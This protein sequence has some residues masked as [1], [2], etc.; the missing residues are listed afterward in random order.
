MILSSGRPKAIDVILKSLL[1]F[2]QFGPMKL[3]LK[4]NLHLK[5]QKQKHLM[6]VI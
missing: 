1:V 5:K 2:M 3:H 6:T 4:E